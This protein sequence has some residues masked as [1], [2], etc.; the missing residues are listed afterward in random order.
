MLY[1][2]PAP[3]LIR[4]QL[5][6]LSSHLHDISADTQAGLVFSRVT[7]ILS[8]RKCT[9]V[10]LCLSLEGVGQVK[11]LQD[12]PAQDKHYHLSSAIVRVVT[13]MVG[14]MHSGGACCGSRTSR[15][16]HLP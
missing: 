15:C 4:V 10:M 7:K 2:S 5:Q 11:E 6:G 14:Y 8:A 9:Q 16:R 13:G 3:I 1:A 12:A